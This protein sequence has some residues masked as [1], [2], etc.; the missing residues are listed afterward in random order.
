M[1]CIIYKSDADLGS[2]MIFIYVTNKLCQ[3]LGWPS[4]L[5][6]E[7]MLGYKTVKTFL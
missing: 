6:V 4:E 1:K 2:L 3:A 5:I 7:E